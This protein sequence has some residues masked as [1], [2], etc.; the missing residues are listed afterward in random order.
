MPAMVEEEGGVQILKRMAQYK[1]SC[2]TRKKEPSA[3][4]S[5]ALSCINLV[6]IL[7]QNVTV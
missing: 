5:S 6:E 1:G 2:H 7:D 4:V 3:P